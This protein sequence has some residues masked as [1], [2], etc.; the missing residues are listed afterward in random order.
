MQV[1]SE[2]VQDHPKHSP[3]RSRTT[4]SWANWE[5][6]ARVGTMADLPD[7]LFYEADDLTADK[8]VPVIISMPKGQDCN[9]A[10]MGLKKTG[11]V[12]LVNG[13]IFEVAPDQLA[14]LRER[15]PQDA[16]VAINARIHYDMPLKVLPMIGPEENSRGQYSPSLPGI[17]KVWEKGFTGKGTTIAII[18]SGI[19]PHADLKD[20]VKGW[21]D[22]STEKKKNM[23][24]PFGHG[25]HVAGL[26]AGNGSKSAGKYKGIA[27]EADLVGV[28]ITTVV[29]AIRALQWVIENKEKYNIS[30]VNMSLGDYAT[31]SYKDDPWAQ[32]TQKAIEAG[33]TVIVAAGNEG[34]QPSTISTPGTNPD[35]ITV[36]A[37][38]DKGTPDNR[39]DDTVASFSSRGPTAVDHLNKP[40]ILAPGVRVFGPLSPNA[41]LDVPDLPHVGKDYFAMSGTSQATPMA[42][43]LAAIL[44]QANPK[45]THKDI[46]DILI[47]S[48][49]HN[50]KDDANAQGAGLINAEKALDL[51]LSWGKQTEQPKAA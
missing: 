29:E 16:H 44:L 46:K 28:R 31:K 48:A 3:V 34:P 41:K 11:D 7:D 17:E 24:D 36:G 38:D 49:D 33:L 22:L 26:A 13:S 4:P 6:E 5:S 35:A 50:L 47:K 8:N 51:A 45:L 27:P 39:A 12:P 18:D 20:R 30:V 15:L 37:Y 40:D 10:S 2:R 14:S 42:S 9:F 25:T 32:A 21:V 19:Y 23:T 1:R 43:G